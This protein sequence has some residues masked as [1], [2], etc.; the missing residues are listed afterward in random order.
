[1]KKLFSVFVTVILLLSLAACA[2]EGGK[3]T[4]SPDASL[5]VT[6][7]ASASPYPEV[8][9]CSGPLYFN[10][11]SQLIE[12][13]V[14]IRK[15][16]ATTGAF[17]EI[18]SKRTGIQNYNVQ[19]DEFTLESI[20][21]FYKPSKLLDEMPL[22]EIVVRGEYVS[23][24]YGDESQGRVATFTW[25]REMSPE[26]AMNDLY[27]RGG[28]ARELVYDGIEYLFL[29]WSGSD[30]GLPG[31]YSVHWVVDNIPYQASIP[32]GHTDAEML[33]FCR[34]EVVAVQ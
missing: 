24:H 17:Y 32:D 2:G 30:T 19:N 22:R 12:T 23:L 33:V 18:D 3:I 34:W 31:G 6:A 29:H 14:N 16:K 25:L 20:T 26:V 9:G 13:I 28:A 1:M 8:V 11:E 7:S 15:A 27:N 4:A 21:Q 5:P 10:D